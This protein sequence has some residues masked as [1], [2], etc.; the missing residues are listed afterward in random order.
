[1]YGSFEELQLIFTLK[2]VRK[3]CYYICV[4]H[5]WSYNQDTTS[6]VPSIPPTAISIYSRAGSMAQKALLATK[7]VQLSRKKWDQLIACTVL[8]YPQKV[9]EADSNSSREDFDLD[10]DS[11]DDSEEWSG[12]WCIITGILGEV[13]MGVQ[14]TSFGGLRPFS[15]TTILHVVLVPQYPWHLFCVF[16]K[17]Y[18]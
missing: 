1:M 10:I 9:P 8:Q 16:Y 18:F 13:P 5:G 12:N 11:E 14:M 6:I 3:L 15:T 7:Q 4:Q 2:R 17:H